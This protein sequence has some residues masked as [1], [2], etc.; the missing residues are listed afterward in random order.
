MGKKKITK[1]NSSSKELEEKSLFSKTLSLLNPEDGKALFD[2]LT[3]IKN[4]PIAGIST[5]SLGLDYVICPKAGGMV[6][7]HCIELYGAYS[8]GKSTLA[9]GLCANVTTRK[10][11][12]LYV[13]AERSFSWEMALNAGVNEKYFTLCQHRDAR[14]VANSIETLI[15]TGEVG[16]VVI[17]S[18]PFWKPLLEL[19]KGSDDVDITKSQMA[20]QAA[21][22]TNTLPI[23]AQV[24]ADHGVILILINQERKNLSGY[25]GGSVAYGCE[26]QKHI[27]SVRLRLSGNVKSKDNK[28]FDSEGILVG[29]YVDVVADK[30]KIS[31]PMRETR[32]PLFFGRGVNPY[33]EVAFLSIKAGIVNN[34]AG[35]IK[36]PGSDKDIAYG[37]DNYVQVLFDNTELYLKIRTLVAEYLGIKYTANTR[38]I[39]SFHDEIGIKR[40][41][42]ISNTSLNN[43]EETIETTV[44]KTLDDNE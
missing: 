20:F 8:T 36:M 5:G 39:N 33:M 4:K 10:K 18:I 9:L 29:Q 41:N 13:D 24:A 23:L 27:N 15:K 35:H 3:T 2:S 21:F 12:V 44:E 19:K 16:A 30:N 22:I 7:G 6:E 11:Q 37:I 28:I 25:G 40:E 34:G 1:T 42:I 38:I 43:S 32:V 17:D 26:A 14:L 31:G